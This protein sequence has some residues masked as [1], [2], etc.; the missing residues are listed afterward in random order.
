[1]I[2]KHM[3]KTTLIVIGSIVILASAL[4][5]FQAGVFDRINFVEE[6]RGPYNLVYKKYK[7]SY[8]S[9]GYRIKDVYHYVKTVKKI[10]A[11][12]GGFTVF[13]DNPQKTRSDSLRSICGV[14]TDSLISADAPYKAAV[15][16]KANC[17]VGKFPL[18]SYFSY[19]S[20]INKLYPALEK[21]AKIKNTLINGPVMEVIDTK[22]R[23]IIYIV[24]VSDTTSVPAFNR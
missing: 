12:D 22:K 7:G 23:S 16:V 18:R 17:I 3:L 13:Y 9:A 8:S 24:S 2:G 10:D 19:M 4:L 11:V 21:Y 20:G 15:Y 14:F 1:M 5:S 6:S